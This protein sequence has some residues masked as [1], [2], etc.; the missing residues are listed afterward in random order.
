MGSEREKS[1]F[2]G[3]LI[4]CVIAGSILFIMV[5]G[6]FSP[7]PG[8]RRV[9]RMMDPDRMFIEQMIPHHQDAIDMATWR[10]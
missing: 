9:G 2:V 8:E 6:I 4:I 7:Y 1:L 5:T 10:W 3:I